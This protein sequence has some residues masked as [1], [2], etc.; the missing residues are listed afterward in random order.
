MTICHVSLALAI[1]NLGLILYIIQRAEK[2]RI[3]AEAVDRMLETILKKR[4]APEV[5]RTQPE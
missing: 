4:T 3:S 2:R 1:F 5:T